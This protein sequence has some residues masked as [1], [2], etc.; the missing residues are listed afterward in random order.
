MS[1]EIPDFARK[2]HCAGA[3]V[4]ETTV[5]LLVLCIKRQ[6][7]IGRSAVYVS[8]HAESLVEQ[9]WERRSRPVHLYEQYAQQALAGLGF[10][11]SLSW[12]QTAGCECG[13]SPGFIADRVLFTSDEH[14]GDVPIDIHIEFKQHAAV[15]RQST[16]PT[17]VIEGS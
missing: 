7:S 13:C 11:T 10:R 17:L 8:P 6:H 5:E 9:L 2:T 12:S 15:L 14:T 1:I 4:L 3:A 16:L